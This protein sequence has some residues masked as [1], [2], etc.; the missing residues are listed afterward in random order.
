MGTSSISIQGTIQTGLPISKLQPLSGSLD[1]ND[2]FVVSK[3][4]AK[5]KYESLR[6]DISAITGVISADI[7]NYTVKNIPGISVITNDLSTRIE[8]LSNTMSALLSVI[9]P[10]AYDD[11]NELADKNFV[12]SSI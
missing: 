11:G 8:D 2:Y 9:P 4:N 3:A 5:N 12:N 7:Y 6:C 10:Q 1:G